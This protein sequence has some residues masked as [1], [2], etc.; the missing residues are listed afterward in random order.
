[1]VVILADLR[2]ADPASLPL[3]EFADRHT[4]V[5][6]PLIGT[7]RDV[8]A[9]APSHPLHELMPPLA[10]KATTITRT[11]LDE[12][13][14]TELMNR[15]VGADPGAELAADEHRWNPSFVAQTAPLWRSG[16]TQPPESPTHASGGLSLSSGQSPNYSRTPQC[17]A[18]NSPIK[19]VREA[20]A[21]HCGGNAVEPLSLG[22]VRLELAART[23]ILRV[24]ATARLRAAPRPHFLE[25]R[26]ARLATA[27]LSY[28]AKAD[29]SPL[30]SGRGCGNGS[31]TAAHNQGSFVVA[32]VRRF[33]AN[34]MATRP[35]S[36]AE[37]RHGP[38]AAHCRHAFVAR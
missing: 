22:R 31:T 8:E 34:Q 1:M 38:G 13:G 10:V 37:S 18:A 7:Y 3:I 28:F 33:A 32:N 27:R 15:T 23:T 26:P 12:T 19:F 16:S 24:L 14:V 11:G 35:A 36:G 30:P 29:S 6:Q 4:W 2:W 21:R 5:E 17:S 9:D 25:A 20:Q